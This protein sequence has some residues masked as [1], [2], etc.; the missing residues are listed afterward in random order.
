MKQGGLAALLLRWFDQYQRDLPWR[1][2]YD[3]YQVWISEIMLQQTQMERGVQ[4]FQ[5]WLE[6]FPDC[7]ALAAAD[8]DEVLRLWEGL[9]YYARARNLHRAAQQVMQQYAGRLPVDYDQLLEL[10]GIGPYTAAAVVSIAH[11][12]PRPVLDANVQRLL[13]R[14]LDIDSPIMQAANQRR[15]HHTATE[16]LV[17]VSPRRLNQALMEFGALV[18]TPRKPSCTSCPVAVLCRAHRIGA[19]EDRPVRGRRQERIAIEMACAV[20]CHQSLI[21]IQQREN[22]DVWGGLW[23]FPGGRIETGEQAAAAALR[24]I[25]EETALQVGELRPLATVVHHYTRYRVTLHGFLCEL[26]QGE[27]RPT[28]TAAQQF[29][30]V[31]LPQLADHAFPA[32]HRRLRDILLRQFPGECAVCLGDS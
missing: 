29:R 24:E 7:S 23:E 25:R 3:P 6:R 5:R 18:C 26:Q 20:I 14:I 28:L 2:G 9:G 4:Y 1:R 8:I 10:P 31:S 13:A 22:D 17:G 11:D 16:L 15:L 32:G 12:Q 30:W 27:T 21:F 19:E